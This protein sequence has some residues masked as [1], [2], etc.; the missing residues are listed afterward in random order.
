MPPAMQSPFERL[1]TLNVSS[2]EE[3]VHRRKPAVMPVRQHVQVDGQLPAWQSNVGA[4]PTLSVCFCAL[5]KN[6]C[7]ASAAFGCCGTICCLL[8][9]DHQHSEDQGDCIQSIVP[10]AFSGDI[11]GEQLEVVL[12]SK[13]LVSSSRRMLACLSLLGPCRETC[14]QLGLCSNANMGACN[15]CPL[16]DLGFFSSS[17]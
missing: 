1:H 3:G 14:V 9:H 12:Q 17:L 2:Q 4:P 16:L 10:C 8:G 11:N 6:R 5:G 15:V 13:D 7:G